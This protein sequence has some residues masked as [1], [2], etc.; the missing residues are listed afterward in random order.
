VGA[1]GKTTNDVVNLEIQR[2]CTNSEVTERLEVHELTSTS[3]PLKHRRTVRDNRTPVEETG[4][5]IPVHI[6]VGDDHDDGFRVQ[7]RKHTKRFCLLGLASRVNEEVLSTVISTKGPTVT[8]ILV[9]PLRN[10]DKVLIRLNVI[11][12]EIADIVLENGF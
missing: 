12:D 3:I 6:T 7:Q 11:A 4:S 10:S 5:T 8:P 9:F 2:S 1:H